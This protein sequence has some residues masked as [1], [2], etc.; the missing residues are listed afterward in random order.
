MKF[1]IARDK[2]GYLTL[3]KNK[4]KYR[5]CW[6]GSMDWMD[7]CRIANVIYDKSIFPEVA[8]ENS[9]QEVEFKLV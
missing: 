7:G 2:S 4:P 5:Y 6:N 8:F 1:W 9:P 3:W